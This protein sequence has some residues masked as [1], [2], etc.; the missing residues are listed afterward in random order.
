MDSVGQ[1]ADLQRYG[2]REP[3]TLKRFADGAGFSIRPVF[4]A[5][6]TAFEKQTEISI[7]P[8]DGLHV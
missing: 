7:S 5:H 3:S 2:T 8:K 6:L 4:I 1:A